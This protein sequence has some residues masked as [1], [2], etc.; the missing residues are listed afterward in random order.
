MGVCWCGCA[1]VFVC[2]VSGSEQWAG[3][4]LARCC[5]SD[6]RCG[7]LVWCCGLQ[8]VVPLVTVQPGEERAWRRL[9]QG[10]CR[11]V[12]CLCGQGVAS[13]GM[14]RGGV[15][16]A[17]AGVVGRVRLCRSGCEVVYVGVLVTVVGQ[18]L[19]E[20]AQGHVVAYVVQVCGCY[21][22]SHI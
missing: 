6:V 13:V 1:E 4:G 8:E 11:H 16:E 19:E 2:G 12:V 9:S 22:F 10:E 20:Q 3:R 18:P 14:W 5:V 21:V 15:S 7:V 17:T